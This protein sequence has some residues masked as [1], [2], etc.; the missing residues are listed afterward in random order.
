MEWELEAHCHRQQG[1]V[2]RVQH[3]GALPEWVD[4]GLDVCWEE[5]GAP[6]SEV[7]EQPPSEV[8]QAPVRG[9]GPVTSSDKKF[10]VSMWLSVS[11]SSGELS[12]GLRRA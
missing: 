7:T 5:F 4:F 1:G 12:V 3:L 8:V 2:H 11:G 6:P 9:R 10:K